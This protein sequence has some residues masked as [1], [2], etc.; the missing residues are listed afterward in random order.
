M[1]FLKTLVVSL[2]FSAIATGASAETITIAGHTLENV[3]VSRDA[4]GIGSFIWSDPD[5]REWFGLIKFI[6]DDNS[7]CMIRPD[8]SVTNRAW[9]MSVEPADSTEQFKSFLSAIDI[10]CRGMKIKTVALSAY[11]DFFLKGE[12]ESVPKSALDTD[13]R[14]AV[15]GSLN[16][17]AAFLMCS[18]PRQ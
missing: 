1:K 5:N 8:Y 15:P 4:D 17:A 6:E 10:D 2:C 13:Y 14:A 9:I 7:I 11:S 12:S 16:H 3:T 18:L